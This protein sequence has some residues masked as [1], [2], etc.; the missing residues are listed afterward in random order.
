MK[1]GSDQDILVRAGAPGGP[2]DLAVRKLERCELSAYAELAAAVANQ[3]FAVDDERRHRDRFAVADVAG[4]RLPD[5]FA[6][7]RVQRDGLIVE[8]VEDD[9]PVGV[10]GAPVDDVAARNA[11]RG[12]TRVGFIGPLHGRGGVPD[13]ER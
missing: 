12:G 11:L 6:G 9:L 8:R 13:T 10:D 5:L 3:H 4:P 7:R 2:G 1:P